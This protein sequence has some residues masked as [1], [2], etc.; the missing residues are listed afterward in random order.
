MVFTI[1][2]V[3]RWAGKQGESGLAVPY[4]IRQLGIEF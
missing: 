2:R 1:L 4:E 3:M